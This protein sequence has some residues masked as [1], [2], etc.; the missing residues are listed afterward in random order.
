MYIKV[1]Y[2]NNLTIKG[3]LVS[4][5]EDILRGEFHKINVQC[6]L[7]HETILKKVSQCCV[8][9]PHILPVYVRLSQT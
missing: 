4:F 8:F 2:T 7:L 3:I 9:T 6:P 1:R 5:H